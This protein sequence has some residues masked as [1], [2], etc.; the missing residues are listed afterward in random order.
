MDYPKMK[1]MKADPVLICQW[2]PLSPIQYV[3]SNFHI[4]WKGKP[5]PNAS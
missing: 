4:E 1:N 2:A 3:K 5:I